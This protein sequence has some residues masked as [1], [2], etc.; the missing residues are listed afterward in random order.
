[1]SEAENPYL[2]AVFRNIPRLLSLIN[3][4]TT[5]PLYGCGDRR[6]WAWK[7]IDF[8]NGTFQGAAFGFSN[9]IA[10]N[11][12]PDYL[13]K[14]PVLEKILAMIS[15]MPKL[16]DRNGALGEALPNEG[17]FCVTGLVLSDCLGAISKLENEL[18]DKQKGLLLKS[19]EPLVGFLSSQDE[20]HGIISNHLA[21][22]ALGLVRW[23]KLSE[24]D[25]ALDLAEKWIN[26]IRNNASDEGWF[27]EYG[28]A[29]PGY[30]SWCCASLAQIELENPRFGLTEF[31]D[32][33]FNFL[34]AFA[35]P[36]GSWANGCGSRMT[37]F[38]LPGCAELFAAKSLS[39]KRLAGF[40]R[41]F[42]DKN[43]FV[44]LDSVDEPNLVPFFND[45]VLAAVSFNC[46]DQD[47][48]LPVPRN[49]SFPEAGIRVSVQNN[50]VLVVNTQRGGWLSVCKDQSAVTV[51]SEPA[52]TDTSGFVLR[53]VNGIEQ[54]DKNGEIV[55]TSDLE[56]V[57][58]MMPGAFKFFILR[59]LSMTAFR[60]PAF[61]NFIKR[62]IARRLMEQS[63]KSLG[64]VERRINLKTGE[65]KDQILSGNCKIIEN[66]SG[67]SPMHMASQGYWQISDDTSFKS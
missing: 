2:G 27:R 54:F 22:T 30:Q 57:E 45:W 67:F 52:A 4:D 34:E 9:L 32:R 48:G 59:V 47:N 65:F 14:A 58:R 37:R 25:R 51:H 8:P 33:G 29:D 44:G 40:A 6:Y 20:T 61:G 62:F 11:M 63:G 1:M 43:S 10:N 31:L 18:D 36:D 46:D 7:T 28:G 53:P 42:A 50:N 24:N 23:A 26:R 38:L 39:A 16:V 55:V 17:S 19:L 64:R 60:I 3:V 41:H 15:V 12:L 5:H 21:T 56:R 66:T 49:R 35:M 13:S